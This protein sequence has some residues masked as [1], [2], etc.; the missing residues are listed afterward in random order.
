MCQR[1][2]LH[3]QEVE[4]QREDQY[5]AGVPDVDISITTR[6]LA[7][8]IRKVG[9]NFRSLPDEGFDDP[10]GESTGAGVIFR[11]HRRRYEA[12]LRDCSGKAD[13]KRAGKS[14]IYGS[15]RNRRDQRGGL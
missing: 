10:V 5:A 11:S 15:A 14:G 13:G 6:E 4:I 2:A 12:A 7:R 1:Y 3:G 8:L 9:I